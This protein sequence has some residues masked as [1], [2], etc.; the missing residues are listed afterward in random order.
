MVCL[1]IDSILALISECH[2]NL[3]KAQYLRITKM[4]FEAG[5]YPSHRRCL[6]YWWGDLVIKQRAG[7]PT[8]KLTHCRATGGVLPVVI[9]RFGDGQD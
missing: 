8:G 5:F 1:S 6:C 9:L 4:F 7:R 3:F 2:I